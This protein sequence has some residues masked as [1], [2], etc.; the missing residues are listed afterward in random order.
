MSPAE[1][2]NII[3]AYLAG[4]PVSDEQLSEASEMLRSD[5]DYGR[6][7]NEEIAG[8]EWVSGCDLFL[9]RAAEFCELAPAERL[10]R[11]PELSGHVEQCPACREVF[12]RIRP[13][14][15]S[16]ATGEIKARA[17]S[18]RRVLAEQI[19]IAASTAGRLIEQGLGPLAI[20]PR[21]VAATAAPLGLDAMPAK[22]WELPDDESG[23][24][25][26]L[27]VAARAEDAAAAIVCSIDCGIQ[28]GPPPPVRLEVREQA[29][30]ALFLGGRLADFETEPIVLPA[31]SWTLRL[32]MTDDSGER[33]W[34]VPL[35]IQFA[36]MP[37]DDSEW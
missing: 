2:K 24:V 13:L 21:L 20:E 22:Q 12:W 18:L 35:S 23:C 36:D 11:M 1:A 3:A 16:R 31:G 10:R 37:S 33:I 17:S 27:L 4:R 8:G 28:T 29:T 5:S 19:R 14:W 26:R 9:S 32:R 15:T 34:E 30:D 6:Y 7:L 25:I